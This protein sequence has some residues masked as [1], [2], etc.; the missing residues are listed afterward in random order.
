MFYVQN[1][2]VNFT[3]SEF[4]IIFIEF[5]LSIHHQGENPGYS[6]TYHCKNILSRKHPRTLCPWCFLAVS[7][8]ELGSPD[9]SKTTKINHTPIHCDLWCPCRYSHLCNCALYTILHYTN[10]QRNA[11]TQM[12]R[13][14][15]TLHY[16]AQTSRCDFAQ[17]YTVPT[18]IPVTNYH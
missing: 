9:F 8:H 11:V 1:V 13:H 10:S 4:I 14:N 6:K 17:S 16:F 15:F 7:Y 12:H 2:D 5:F 3:I 18:L